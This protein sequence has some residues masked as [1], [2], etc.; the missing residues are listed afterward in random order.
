VLLLDL[1][2]AIKLD[3]WD[4]NE[5]KS[6]HFSA[7]RCVNIPKYLLYMSETILIGHTRAFSLLAFLS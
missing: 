4:H 2:G 7:V 1:L 3:V 6:V 5:N